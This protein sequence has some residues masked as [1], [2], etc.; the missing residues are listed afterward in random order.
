M[1]PLVNTERVKLAGKSIGT[2]V[3]RSKNITLSKIAGFTRAR[4]I[5]ARKYSGVHSFTIL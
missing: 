4:F 3:N 5:G 2:G 1:I